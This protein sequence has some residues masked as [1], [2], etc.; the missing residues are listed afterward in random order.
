MTL[1]P[2]VEAINLGEVCFFLFQG[3]VDACCRWVLA[4]SPSMPRAS[5]VVLLWVGRGSL[6]SGRW[7]FPTRCVSKD[8][9][10]GFIFSTGVFFLPFSGPILPGTLWVHVAGAGK[11]LQQCL[12]LCIDGFLD[13]LFLRVEVPVLGIQL[14]LDKRPQAFPEVSDYDFLVWSGGGI[15]F[16]EDRLQVLQVCCPVKDFL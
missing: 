6:L 11:G 16:S 14:G 15:K 10:G 12:C 13:G 7:L 3:D 2:A 1:F 4:S 5:A 8:G 9:V